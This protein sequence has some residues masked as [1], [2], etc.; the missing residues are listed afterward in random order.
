MTSVAQRIVTV[1]AQRGR[2]RRTASRQAPAPAAALV[3]EQR[4]VVVS[5][6]V[7]AAAPSAALR[8]ISPSRSSGR[9]SSCAASIVLL[10]LPPRRSRP[11]HQDRCAHDGDDAQYDRDPPSIPALHRR[12]SRL[13]RVHRTSARGHRQRRGI[14]R[15]GGLRNIAQ[16]PQQ[17]T[18]GPV[19]EQETHRLATDELN[20]LA[21]FP[22]V[23]T[24]H[25]VVPSRGHRGVPGDQPVPS[26]IRQ[27]HRL[28][29]A[30]SHQRQVDRSRCAGG[31]QQTHGGVGRGAGRR[32]V[33]CE[34]QGYLAGFGRREQCERVRH[35]RIERE[36][37]T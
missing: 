18:V 6:V 13:G 37:L 32:A 17:G 31:V 23:C 10:S 19:G 21:P 11:G 25:C 7:V 16:R 15:G 29:H 26:L 4:R 5:A 8:T 35:P 34:L 20:G 12:R 3:Q 22:A 30:G 2:A 1:V 27:H 28:D 14:Q 33:R 36:H 9:T 24:H